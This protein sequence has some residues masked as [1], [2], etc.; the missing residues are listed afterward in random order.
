[1]S[2]GYYLKPQQ[3]QGVRMLSRPLSRWRIHWRRRP[4]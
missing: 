2:L 1:V 4:A 3:I